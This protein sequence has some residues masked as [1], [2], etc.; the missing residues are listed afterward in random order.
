L[1]QQVID[2]KPWIVTLAKP[3]GHFYSLSS[4]VDRFQG[5]V[6]ADLYARV[7]VPEINDAWNE[8]FGP[9]RRWRADREAFPVRLRLNSINGSAQVG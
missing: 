6:D 7:I 8:P 1:S 4:G 2:L 3:Y 5:G 9:K